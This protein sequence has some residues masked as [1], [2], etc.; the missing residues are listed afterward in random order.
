[1]TVESFREE[2]R[3]KEKEGERIK[4]DP[5]GVDT[6]RGIKFKVS[7]LHLISGGDGE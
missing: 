3:E 2:K 7:A 4:L 6:R 5:R 1:M